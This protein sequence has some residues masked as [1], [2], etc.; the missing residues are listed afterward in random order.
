MQDTGR[1]EA[2]VTIVQYQAVKTFYWNLF[3]FTKILGT[4]AV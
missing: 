1:S 4:Q 3:K 2:L